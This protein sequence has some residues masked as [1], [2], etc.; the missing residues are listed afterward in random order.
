M[1]STSSAEADQPLHAGETG[2][3]PEG[4]DRRGF[5]RAV[6]A[7]SAMAVLRPGAAAA[8]EAAG[9]APPVKRAADWFIGIQMSPHSMLD[10]GI[11]RCLDLIQETASVNAIMVYSHA[12]GGD[13][14]KSA[15]ILAQDHGV[16]ARDNTTRKLPVVWARPHE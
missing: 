9:A 2:V 15:R 3:A 7:G 12:Y 13:M 14:R 16:P 6:T 10:E 4:L 1:D 11:E 8:Q 5:I